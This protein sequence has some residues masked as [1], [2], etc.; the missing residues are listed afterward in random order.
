VL[1]HLHG[2]VVQQ[3]VPKMLQY[4]TVDRF[5]VYGDPGPQVGATLAN[6]SAQVFGYWGGLN[7]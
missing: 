1:T 4:V 2:A 7:R 5:S 6:F 3:L